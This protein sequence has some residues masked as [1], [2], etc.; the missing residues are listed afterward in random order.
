VHLRKLSRSWGK[1]HPKGIEGPIPGTH[2]R[3]EI[4]PVSNT[5]ENLR[6][7]KALSTQKDWAL[8]VGKN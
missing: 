6:I 4:V 2:T 8:V 1:I 5:E 7:Y 3:T